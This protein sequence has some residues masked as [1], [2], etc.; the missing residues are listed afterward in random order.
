MILFIIA[1]LSSTPC[2]AQ[3]QTSLSNALYMTLQKHFAQQDPIY[4]HDIF[5]EVA[6]QSGIAESK[7]RPRLLAMLDSLDA[8]R[9]NNSET[10]AALLLQGNPDINPER[11]DKLVGYLVKESRKVLANKNN[12]LLEKGVKKAARK[13][14]VPFF[15][16]RAYILKSLEWAQVI[17][18]GLQQQEIKPIGFL[19]G[20]H[21]NRF[22][23][24]LDPLF[25][26][27]KTEDE[28]LVRE[29]VREVQRFIIP[30]MVRRLP[31]SDAI[32]WAVRERETNAL[33][34]P[35]YHLRVGVDN[36]SFSGSNLDLKPCIETT[37][38][39]SHWES[40]VRLM[41][42]S[43]S[44]CSKKNG[45][46]STQELAPFWNEA[47]DAIREHSLKRLGR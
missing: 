27:F 3:E 13:A 9:K 36:L 21:T 12:I 46:A 6:Q 4:S 34:L 32:L 1:L 31:E 10:W 41:Q 43:F 11:T 14:K 39:L 42:E 37:L 30:A 20:G 22:E 40:K 24:S 15:Q 29:Q 25:L 8:Q 47:A 7:L 17:S 26:F 2:L 45:S 38:E 23:V 19:V 28:A 5:D 33:V 44:F 18:G 16:S 35:D